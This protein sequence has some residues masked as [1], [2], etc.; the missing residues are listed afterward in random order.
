MT[1]TRVLF[2]CQHNSARS[3]M[4]E[5]FLNHYGQG[6]FEAMGAGLEPTGINPLAAEAMQETGL[7]ISGNKA[8]DVF[9]LFRSGELF[10]YVITVCSQEVEAKCPMFPGVTD[11][12]NWPFPDPAKT[13]GTHEERLAATRAIRDDIKAR[14]IRFIDDLS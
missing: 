8:T 9:T 10:Q 11:R 13:T 12:Q 3:Q 7:D 4:A 2:I 6:R 5:A 14:I 1:S